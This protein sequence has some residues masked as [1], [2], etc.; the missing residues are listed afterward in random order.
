LPFIEASLGID[1]ESTFEHHDLMYDCWR[2]NLKGGFKAVEAQLGIERECKG[3]TGWDA[4]LLWN[5][6]VEYADRESLDVL[7][8]YNGEDVVNLKMLRLK[9]DGR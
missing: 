4:V 6:Y 8:K 5:K 9:L 1:L 3:I 7:L 2:C